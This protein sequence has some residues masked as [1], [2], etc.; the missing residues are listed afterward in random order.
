LRLAL[1]S[2]AA[3]KTLVL[4]AVIL[5][6][7]FLT[8]IIGPYLVRYDPLVPDPEAI[9]SPP[10]AAHLLGTDNYG[11]DILSRI[12][13]AS[14]LDLTIAF[15]VTALALTVGLLFGAVSGFAGGIVDDVVMRLVDVLLSFPAFILAVAITAMLGK[16]VTNLILAIGIAY[17]PYFLRLTR[18][19]GIVGARERVR[20][21]R[22]CLGNP[23]IALSTA[24]YC[25]TVLL[26]RLSRPR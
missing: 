11:R 26:R 24:T 13:A 15:S 22:R 19:R 23:T 6:G 21:C 16:S 8:A 2:F 12:V 3:R 14:R 4:S 20:R 9:L 7:L 10:S 25:P 1:R 5:V 17:T 18:R